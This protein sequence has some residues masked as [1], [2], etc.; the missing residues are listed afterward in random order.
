MKR[1]ETIS[2]IIDAFIFNLAV[3]LIIISL[4]SIVMLAKNNIDYEYKK[5]KRPVDGQRK[6]IH[7]VM[8]DGKI[9]FR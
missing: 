3:L 5:N 8:R 4:S 2:S 9:T 7:G 6:I 1:S